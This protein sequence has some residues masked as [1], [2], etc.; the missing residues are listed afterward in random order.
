M[1]RQVAPMLQDLAATLNSEEWLPLLTLLPDLILHESDSEHPRPA[2]RGQAEIF[3][4][5]RATLDAFLN[6]LRHMLEVQH[7]GF[8]NPDTNRQALLKLALA[9]LHLKSQLE[10]EP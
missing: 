2:G 6:L 7:A 1:P 3:A 4:A 9:A 5:Y 8:Y 10:V